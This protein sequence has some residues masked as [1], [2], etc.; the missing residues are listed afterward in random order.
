MRAERLYSCA[1]DAK[2]IL[3]DT[4]IQL[5]IDRDIGRSVMKQSDSLPTL[6]MGEDAGTDFQEIEKQDVVQVITT[7]DLL[8]HLSVK[9]YLYIVILL[10]EAPDFEQ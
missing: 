4:V 7:S 9:Y 3:H 6:L 5:V 2:P 8:D 10:L 1:E